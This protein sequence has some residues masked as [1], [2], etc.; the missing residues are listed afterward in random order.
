MFMLLNNPTFLSFLTFMIYRG[1]YTAH[2]KH[3]LD[4][5]DLTAI[6]L[7]LSGDISPTLANTIK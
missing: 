7:C 6:I 5:D 1:K 2:R 3:D 4:D